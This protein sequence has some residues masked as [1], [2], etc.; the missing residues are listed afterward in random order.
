MLKDGKP[1]CDLCGKLMEV[2]RTNEDG[3]SV[4][5][6]EQAHAHICEQCHSLAWDKGFEE[7]RPCE[8]QC[9]TRPC[10]RGN[11]CW[12]TPEVLRNRP[13]ETYFA[14][15]V[16]CE[17]CTPG[18]V[19]THPEPD[20]ALSDEE[21]ASAVEDFCESDLPAI[22]R[23]H[24]WSGAQDQLARLLPFEREDLCNAIR[25]ALRERIE[26]TKRVGV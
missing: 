2:I 19:S 8:T 1:H 13:Y 17:N 25:A 10:N 3:D 15:R 26:E 7:D 5:P 11:E 6:Y 23:S 9:E 21:F 24:L 12:Y 4:W 16:G 18:Y 20:L 14:D 22:L